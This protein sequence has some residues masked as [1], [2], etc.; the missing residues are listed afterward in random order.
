MYDRMKFETDLVIGS[1]PRGTASSAGNILQ[2]YLRRRRLRAA[3]RQ[4]NA[5]SDRMLSDI[6]LDR[7]EIGAAVRGEKSL[8]SGNL[9]RF[10]G[11]HY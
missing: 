4:L 10:N 3:E 6:G 11:R 2:R 9:S 1:S 8:N 7:S 5:M